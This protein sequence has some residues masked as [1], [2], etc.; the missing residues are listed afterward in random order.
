MEVYQLEDL[1]LYE[2]LHHG[3]DLVQKRGAVEDMDLLEP[4]GMGLLDELH[5]DAQGAQGGLR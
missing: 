3:E 4:N 5:V 1:A 2:R